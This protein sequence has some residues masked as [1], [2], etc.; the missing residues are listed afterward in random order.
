MAEEDDSVVRNPATAPAGEGIALPAASASTADAYLLEQTRLAR[1]QS[2]GLIE[3]NAF[4]LS[5]LRW[6]RF[7]D[8][9]KGA[10]QI[11]IVVVGAAAVAAMGAAVWSA[12]HA[13]GLVVDTFAVS[14]SF[15]QA[16]MGGDVIADD[17][18][19]RVAVVRDFA[20][21]H[22]IAHSKDVKNEHDEEIRVEIPDTGVSL[23]DVMRTL[24][25]AL[26]HER[27]LSGNLRSL[28]DG[29]IALTVS[30]D[31]TN[32]AT[33]TGAPTELDALEQRAAEHVFQRVDPSNYVL[34]LAGKGRL[35]EGLAAAEYLVRV[36]DSAPMLS[37]GY[38][39]WGNQTRYTLGDLALTL[40]RERIA[41][42]LDPKAMAP[43]METM[44]AQAYLGHDE[45]RLHEARLLP[46]FRQDEQYAWSEGEG[47]KQVVAEGILKSDVLTGDFTAAARAHCGLC[48]LSDELIQHAEYRARLHD[49]AQSR[50]LIDQAIATGDVAPA[51]VHRSRYFA[52]VEV[53]DWRAAVR[54]ARAY[55]AATTM[56]NT[57]LQAAAVTVFTLPLLAV[58]LA[59]TGDFKHAH[60]EIDKTPGDCVPCEVARGDVD[61]ME[62]NVRGAAWWFARAVHD[63]P[64]IPFADTDWGAML[65]RKGDAAGAIAK[66]AAAH[67]QGP[68]FADPLEMW[69]EALMQQNRSDL[70]LAKFVEA[71][72][73]APNWGRLHLKWAEALHY[74]G[75]DAEAEKQRMLMAGLFLTAADK[76]ELARA[77]TPHV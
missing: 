6:R 52:D 63:A 19:T 42:Q 59:E 18:T 66:F 14:P 57:R 1:L 56:P 75:K 23:A 64:S 39:L 31:G 3:Q 11:M 21:A 50:A 48:T 51:D 32:A 30:L 55:A 9:M 65:M 22:S 15:A 41:M 29:K 74:A 34:Y 58:A 47:F 53:G 45:Q 73:Y 16:G 28:S 12:S 40:Q 68:H 76:K 2:E 67:K 25:A 24:R 72:Q 71:A 33:F 54:D 35:Q 49:V 5:H 61:A 4:E 46:H 13:D 17:L 38:S 44:F 26:G 60:A 70:A 20:N 62:G 7:N 77:G 43:H 27:H 10:M 69:G 8:Q 36:S 37:D